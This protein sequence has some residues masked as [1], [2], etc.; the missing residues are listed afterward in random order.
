M[1]NAIIKWLGI[2]ERISSLQDLLSTK[3]N[4]C[5]GDT[6]D[7]RI[8][9]AS[10]R[11]EVEDLK[12]RVIIGERKPEHKVG[13]KIKNSEG[14]LKV[15]LEINREYENGVL[16]DTYTLNGGEVIEKKYELL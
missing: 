12:E 6:Q 5:I 9:I 16:T 11:L 2:D 3:T 15:I 7:V 4:K 8:S 13:D 1:K 10:L 14:N